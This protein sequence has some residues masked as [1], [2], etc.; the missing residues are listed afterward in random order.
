MAS[1]PSLRGKEA[2]YLA[3]R[4]NQY[5]A[6]E[7][8]GPNSLLMIPVAADLTDDEIEGLAEYIATAFN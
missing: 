8:V 6:G 5:R 7:K 1:F 2:S 4:L 3:E